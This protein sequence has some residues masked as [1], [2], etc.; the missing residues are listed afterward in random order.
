MKIRNNQAFGD[1]IRQLRKEAKLT[2][3][4]VVAQLDTKMGIVIS[5]S[6]YSQIE[7]G[8]YNIKVEELKG[9]KEIFKVS[10]FDAFFENI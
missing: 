6:V 10:S 3:D 5:R 4:Q 2:Q 8:T 1:N 9:L 7:C